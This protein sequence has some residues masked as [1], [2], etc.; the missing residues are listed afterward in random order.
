MRDHQPILIDEFKGLWSRGNIEETPLD[1][2]SDCNNIQFPGDRTFE[3]RDGLGRHQEV[4]SPLSNILRTY[5][6]ATNTANTLLVLTSGGN[7]YHV[8]DST[9]IYGPILTIPSMTDFGFATYGGRAYIT[10]FTTEVSGGL[11]VERGINGEFLYVYLGDGTSAR[12]AGGT[13]ATTTLVVANGAAGN[14]DAGVH[15]FG[16]VFETDTGYLTPPG[17]LVAFTTAANFSVDF[18]S[19]QV[20]GQ[21]FV[22]KRHIVA[23]KVIEDYNGDVNG[24]QLFFI[25]EA[26]IPNNVGT[27]LSNISFFDASLL[28][29]AS[30]LFNN[31]DEI[32]A[33][34]CLTMYQNRMVLTTPYDNPSVAYV[35]A[36]GEPEAFNQVTGLLTVPP[37]GNYITNAAE[38]RDVLYVFKRAKTV[39]FVDNGSEPS[40]WPLGSVDNAM[41]TGVHGIG[42]VLDT[43]GSNVDYL[44]VA[45]YKGL[46]LFNGRYILPELSWKI[47]YLWGQQ[48]FKNS[49]R[50]IQP[51]NDPVK[52]RIYC[53]LTDNTVLFGD[54]SDGFDPKSIKWA[55]WTF[56]V[57]VNCL[58]LI[59]VS[60]L[61][62]G[63]DQAV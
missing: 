37:D 47:Q 24:Y 42:T 52:N 26:T 55:P 58:S 2:F 1:H 48:N 28:E 38:L 16:V 44:L 35:S 50:V 36:A 43:S 59:N 39:S 27:T 62:L 53:V 30:Y 19:V 11:N 49:N 25:P 51:V 22:T 34:V 41:G 17:G 4:A 14:T 5:N 45:S 54:Y 31:F 10:P 20:S 3:T 63:C 46:M 57:K 7:I 23:S 6:Y 32:P 33:G 29:D 13:A 15:I 60:E 40:L 12:K 61:I 56:D 9:T 21:S 8:V 18:S